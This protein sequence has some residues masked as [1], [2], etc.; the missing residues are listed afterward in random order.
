MCSGKSGCFWIEVDGNQFEVHWRHDL[1]REQQVEQCVA[2]LAARQANHD[3]VAFADHAKVGD[4]GTHN[5]AQAFALARE[6]ERQLRGCRAVAAGFLGIFGD[7]QWNFGCGWPD[8]CSILG[9]ASRPRSV[10]A[11]KPT[12]WPR[13]R[14]FVHRCSKERHDAP[15]DHF[16]R[17]FIALAMIVA[18]FATLAGHND[19]RKV[20]RQNERGGDRRRSPA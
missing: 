15:I 1:Q 19:G 11:P 13:S 2:V 3:A 16:V 7:R 18:A 12:L 17:R 20:L 8:S 4:C 5:V 6:R 14:V 9:Q 10:S